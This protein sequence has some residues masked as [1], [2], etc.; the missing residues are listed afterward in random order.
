MILVYIFIVNIKKLLSRIGLFLKNC[1]KYV[2]TIYNL[3]R[4]H[5]FWSLIDKTLNATYQLVVDQ[6]KFYSKNKQK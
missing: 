2:L 1:L 4:K 5:Y 6:E 3:D